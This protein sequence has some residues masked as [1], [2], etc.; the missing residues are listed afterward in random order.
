MI[1]TDHADHAREADTDS[2]ANTIT[3]Y[4][5]SWCGDCRRAKRVFSDFGVS[6]VEVNIEA[7]E[8][9]AELVQS[10]N[11]GLRSVPTILFPDGGVL[12]EP[13]NAALAA[14]LQHYAPAKQ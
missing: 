5:T 12:V 10:L 7:D 14:V 1:S 9:A 8:D 13:S 6:Y 11:N 3:M 2:S 4:T